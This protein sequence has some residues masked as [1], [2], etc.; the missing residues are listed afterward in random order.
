MY[1]GM[2]ARP[3]SMA[4]HATPNIPSQKAPNHGAAPTGYPG[5][6]GAHA[7]SSHGHHSAPGAAAVVASNVGRMYTYNVATEYKLKEKAFSLSGDGFSV[8]NTQTNQLAFKVKGNAFSLKDSKKIQDASGKPI[9]K[10]I[11]NILTLRGRM[12]IVEASSNKSVVTLRKKGYFKFFGAGTVQIWNGDSDEG[13]PWLE[14]KGDF[15]KKNFDF[16]QKASGRVVASVRRKSFNL[17]NLLL[18]KD[19]YIIRIEPGCDNALLV[20]LVIALD[21]QFRDDGNRQ[22]FI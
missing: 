21:E 5:S 7:S 20:F 11:E 12:R 13:D 17:S 3:P 19:T 4:P 10:M 2:G 8:K 15:M 6:S 22:G 16:K 1:A 18:E 14:V 9:Y